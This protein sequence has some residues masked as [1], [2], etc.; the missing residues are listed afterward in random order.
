[1]SDTPLEQV[2][3]WSK[4]YITK[5]KE[6]WITT[7]E[8]VVALAATAGGVRS[9]SEQLQIAEDK[10]RELI[11]SARK[12]LSPSLRAEMETKVDTREY[13][14]GVLPSNE[15]KSNDDE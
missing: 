11:D 13:G 3:G 12:A 9:L 2:S 6:S 7:A 15:H 1:M 5:A 14:L 4:D 10:T 8:Q